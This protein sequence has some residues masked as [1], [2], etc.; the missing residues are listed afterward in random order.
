MGGPGGETDLLV[1]GL[2]RM[3]NDRAPRLDAAPWFAQAFRHNMTLI[4][5]C[6]LS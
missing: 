4:R 1:H 3:V 2:A 6:F 5:A